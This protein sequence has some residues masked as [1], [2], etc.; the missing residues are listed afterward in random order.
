MFNLK[1]RYMHLNRVFAIGLAT[2]MLIVGVTFFAGDEKIQACSCG[3][4]TPPDV[5]FN[6]ANAV[7]TGR[8]VE[9]TAPSGRELA[10]SPLETQI[11]KF[12][13]SS[14]WKG[15]AYETLFVATINGSFCGYDFFEG[16]QYLVYTYDGSPD[17]E[18]WV[19]L[20]SG[21]GSL[22]DAQA[23]GYFDHLGEGQAPKPGTVAATPTPESTL[24]PIATP[25]STPEPTIEPKPTPTPAP[26][27]IVGNCNILAPSAHADF[28]VLPLG[29][30]AGIAWFGFRKR[31]RSSDQ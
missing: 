12:L 26:T 29:L 20:C 16:A 17:H 4:L 6:D 11:V 10:V 28:V 30:V 7:F 19:D 31:S 13:V 22:F 18:F 9:I 24:E 23:W 27:V 15:E 1:D 21:T 2:A 25:T 8:V 14:V 3:Q 5:A